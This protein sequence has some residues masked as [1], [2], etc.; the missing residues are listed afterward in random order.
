MEKLIGH[1]ILSFDFLPVSWSEFMLASMETIQCM[2]ELAF[3]NCT[4]V[5]PESFWYYV[6]CYGSTKLIFVSCRLLV[7]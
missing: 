6:H 2:R 1:S 5:C 4:Y 3:M 7:L